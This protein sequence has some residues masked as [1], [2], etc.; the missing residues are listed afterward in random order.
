[1]RPLTVA[2]FTAALALSTVEVASGGPAVRVQGPLFRVAR[3]LLLLPE[4]ML[5]RGARGDGPGSGCRGPVLGLLGLSFESFFLD[6][7]NLIAL[8]NSLSLSC[9]GTSASNLNASI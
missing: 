3:V 1:M 2:L 4:R 6:F 5:A 9:T 8:L 7:F